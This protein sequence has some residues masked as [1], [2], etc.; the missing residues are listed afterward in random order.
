MYS[1]TGDFY[2][3]RSNMGDQ[4]RSKA[5][6]RTDDLQS[7]HEFDS[8]DSK[9]GEAQELASPTSFRVRYQESAIGNTHQSRGEP[10]WG[11]RSLRFCSPPNFLSAAAT[12]RGLAR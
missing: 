8:M 4:G 3:V 12:S 10:P 2:Y 9:D 11:P 6:G 1:L 5:E 7:S